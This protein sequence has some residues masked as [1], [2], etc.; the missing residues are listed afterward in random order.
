MTVTLQDVSALWG[1]PISGI[2][3]GGISDSQ[4]FAQDIT[5]LLGADPDHK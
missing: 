3:V 4:S 1:L 5:W 2:P